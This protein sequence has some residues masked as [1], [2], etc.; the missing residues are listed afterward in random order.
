MAEQNADDL[1]RE[2]RTVAK[3]IGRIEQLRDRRGQL[4]EEARAAKMT[5][6]D[7]AQLLGMT[8][9]GVEKALYAYQQRRSPNAIAS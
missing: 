2:L 5:I 1:R 3:A 6:R 9:R 8:E 4:I 7:V